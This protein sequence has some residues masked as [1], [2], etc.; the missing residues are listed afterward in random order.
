MSGGSIRASG[1]N[2]RDTICKYAK[3]SRWNRAR[4]EDSP[5]RA[6]GS[7][8]KVSVLPTVIPTPDP[9][10]DAQRHESIPPL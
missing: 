1:W 2:N 4:V 6:V 5:R 7:L 3:V 10:E 8:R 9:V